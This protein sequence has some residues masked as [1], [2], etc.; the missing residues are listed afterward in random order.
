MATKTIL[1]DGLNVEVTDDAE[2]AILKLQ[3]QLADSATAKATADQALKDEQAKVVERDATITAR[4]AK[5]VELETALT[6]AAIT[7][8]KM[9]A[10]GKEYAD[11]CGKAQALSVTFAE[12]A[13]ID[14]VRKAVVDAKMGD[15]AKDYDAAHVAIAF[16]ALTKDA[17]PDPLRQALGSMP[18]IANDADKVVQEARDEMLAE[19][20]G[21]KKTA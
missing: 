7:P 13:D 17:K 11:V 10:A 21:E 9:Q 6:D 20:R 18:L 1:V 12:D 8:A 15:T 5:I 3:G 4:D 19:L 14:A 2:R 16:D